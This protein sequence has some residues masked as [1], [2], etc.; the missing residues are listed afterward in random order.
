MAQET[1]QVS[2]PEDLRTQGNSLSEAFQAEGLGT[3]SHGNIY[4]A[5]LQA[6]RE[7]LARVKALKE[8]PA[9]A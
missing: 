8:N 4:E 9:H 2:I 6:K 1:K 7:F 5:G 3:I